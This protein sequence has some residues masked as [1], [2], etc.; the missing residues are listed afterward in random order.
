MN[1]NEDKKIQITDLHYS[2]EQQEHF[3]PYADIEIAGMPEHNARVR[4]MRAE[5]LFQN[6]NEL[7][8]QQLQAIN[9]NLQ[10]QIEEAKNESKG[11]KHESKIASIRSWISVGVSIIAVAVSIVFSILGVLL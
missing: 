2:N 3:D 5:K 6:E 9:D 1:S 4:E 8:R 10:K 7:T 11:A